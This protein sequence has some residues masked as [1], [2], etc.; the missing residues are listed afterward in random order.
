MVGVG[1]L[2]AVTIP[3]GIVGAAGSGG[4]A[5]KFVVPRLAIY[6][7]ATIHAPTVTEVGT[8][9]LEATLAAYS[10]ATIHGPAVGGAIAATLV[11]YSGVT[12]RTPAVAGSVDLAAT[13]AIYSGATVHAPVQVGEGQTREPALI[14]YS[15]AT[16]H[17]PTLSGEINLEATLSA[18]SG[19]TVHAPTLIGGRIQQLNP[20]VLSVA[21]AMNYNVGEG[22][23]RLLFAGI[24]F[25]G[26]P[27]GFGPPVYGGQE[28]SQVWLI[29]DVG[30]NAMFVLDEAGIQA[31][32][33]NALVWSGAGTARVCAV[34]SYQFADQA[35]LIVDS[36][37]VSDPDGNSPAFNLDTL[38]EGLA[39]AQILA[40]AASSVAWTAPM[41]ERG[42]QVSGSLT[43]SVAHLLP[44]TGA[45]IS[46]E[47]LASAST[48]DQSGVGAASFKANPV[49][50]ELAATLATYSGVTIHSPIVSPEAQTLNATLVA[51]SG[52][53]IHSPTI[54][55]FTPESIAG[56]EL[57]LDAS[58]AASIT[59]SS[60]EV[61]QWDDQ[62][63]NGNDHEQSTG[64]NQPN[65]DT[66]NSNDSLFFDGSDD[67]IRDEAASGLSG[68]AKTVAIV[69]TPTDV[70]S[71]DRML[72]RMLDSGFSNIL[73]VQQTS[74]GDLELLHTATPS[75]ALFTIAGVIADDVTRWAIIRFDDGDQNGLASNGNSG[76]DTETTISTATPTR[77]RVG[78]TDP[79]NRFYPGHI[80]EILVYGGVI[81]DAERTSLAAYFENKWNI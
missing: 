27:T 33:D 47:A 49:S 41:V 26:D 29:S 10:G 8:T 61:S 16:I 52:V 69:F 81:S 28:L 56:L 5:E 58:D 68:G 62:T 30:H 9:I 45:T 67:F 48:P 34:A 25:E 3:L 15:G 1:N 12:I 66:I 31:A 79:S 75:N 14:T 19:A 21:S 38:A 65:T 36:D 55:L 37:T 59:E 42:E 51:Y 13:L 54:A 18:Y 2:Y 77:S 4:A 40:D 35:S 72:Y 32:E 11:V 74:G 50:Q 6:S 43:G 63:A 44:T 20:W 64:T 76:S 80:H 24:V 60:G 22:Q 46:I 57:W 7:G 17:G 53:T 23:N 39:I 70:A 71:T 73:Q 78:S